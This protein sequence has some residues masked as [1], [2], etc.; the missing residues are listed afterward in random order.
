M[1]ALHGGWKKLRSLYRRILYRASLLGA[2]QKGPVRIVVGSNGVFQAGWYP[3][4]ETFL[5]LLKPE[6]WERIFSKHPAEAILAEHV[7]EHLTEAQGLEAARTCFRFLKPGGYVRAA[8]PDGLHPDPQYRNWAKPGGCGPSADDHKLFYT[9][10]TLRKAFEEAGFT[11]ELLEYFDEQGKFHAS[12][13]DPARG[14]IHRSLK[15]DRRN[16]DG[17]PHY[18]SIILDAWK[19]GEPSRKRP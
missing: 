13:W 10:K 16:R 5:D 15:F 2:A 4:E 18:T 17:R 3:T 9:Y 11:V 7:W 1:P 19:P 8:V 14:R 6:Q 12:D